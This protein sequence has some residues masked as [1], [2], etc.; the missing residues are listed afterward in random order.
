MENVLDSIGNR[1]PPIAGTVNQ[2]GRSA[3]VGTEVLIFRV[4]KGLQDILPAAVAVFADQRVALRV[5]PEG[6]NAGCQNNQLPAVGNGHAGAVNGLVA[7]PGR[8]KFRRIQIHH[9]FLNTVGYK[10]DVLLLRKSGSRGQTAAAFPQE[11]PVQ[12][13]FA[14]GRGT[15]GQNKENRPVLQK[16]LH[17]VV[18]DFSNGGLFSAHHPLHAIYRAYHMGAVDH[19][20]AAN[21][22]KQVFGMV[23]HSHNLMGNDLTGRNDQIVCRIHDPAVDL[24]IHRILPETLGDLLHILRRDL[25]QSK[26]IPPPVM[27]H[28]TFIRNVSVHELPLLLCYRRVGSQ[29]RQNINQHVPGFQQMIVQVCDFP[30]LRMESGK[31]RRND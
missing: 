31:I 23:C 10:I 24:H 30:G 3:H 13:A 7:Q 11:Q 1:E 18:K 16:M 8:V 17:A 25:S 20:V 21:A 27:D 19:P 9:A 22:Y 2:V 29:C 28:H 4:L 14:F 26:H 5:L 12:N 15:H 6:G